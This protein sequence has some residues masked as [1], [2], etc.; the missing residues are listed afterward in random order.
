MIFNKSVF[1]A[2]L[3]ASATTCDAALTRH[4][5]RTVRGSTDE[6]SRFLAPTKGKGGSKSKSKKDGLFTNPKKGK[7]E[8][9]I[10]QTTFEIEGSTTP[11][12]TGLS[13]RDCNDLL[14]VSCRNRPTLIAQLTCIFSDPP[15]ADLV[16]EEDRTDYYKC[17]ETKGVVNSPWVF[18]R[19]TFGSVVTFTN[20]NGGSNGSS[21]SVC[22]KITGNPTVGQKADIELWSQEF[23]ETRLDDFN[24]FSVDYKV[25]SQ[26]TPTATIEYY[27]NIYVR[28]NEDVGLF[29]D[30]RF[31][32][33]PDT[34]AP[35]AP[36]LPT[37]WKPLQVNMDT[38]T[39]QT[40]KWS[41][42][43]ITDCSIYRTL[44]D[45]LAAYPDAVFGVGNGQLET[46]DLVA[47]G[48]G[49]SVFTGLEVCWDNAQVSFGTE[50]FVYDFEP[51][52]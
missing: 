16:P 19:D 46:I 51:K 25:V 49:S 50:S 8:C 38:K 28:R 11:I 4:S 43:D 48:G 7:E 41:K 2:L 10:T 3:L 34:V 24:N 47:G 35:I 31:D 13:F 40:A 15:P 12:Q 23:F 17:L 36:L 27:V 44:N 14:S 5:R 29:Y 22:S 30:C 32:Y 37:E 33:K 1:A 42:S 45:F 21:G 39:F 18:I 52:V 6:T 9:A 20:A 26:S